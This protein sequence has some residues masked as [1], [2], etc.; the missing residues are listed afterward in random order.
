MPPLKVILALASAPGQ[1]EGD[2][3]TR[4][5][6]AIALD[7]AGHPDPAAWRADPEPWHASLRRPGLPSRSGDVQYDPDT[8][9][10]ITFFG[11]EAQRPD[12]PGA[13]LAVPGPL[14]PGEYVTLTD[15]EG[16]E[17]V[18]RVVSIASMDC[19]DPA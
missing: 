15:P 12:M 11:S 3:D 9:W 6:L 16:G 14:R 18:F 4:L 13:P 7:A 2:P 1:P 19:A 8:G 10:C 17:L 5:E